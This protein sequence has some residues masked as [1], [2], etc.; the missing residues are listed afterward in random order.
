MLQN[1]SN[2]G[3]NFIMYNLLTPESQEE[4][5]CFHPEVEDILQAH[6]CLWLFCRGQ[7]NLNKINM[8]GLLTETI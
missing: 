2:N 1:L 5:K 3:N 6:E 4:R 8:E 7:Q